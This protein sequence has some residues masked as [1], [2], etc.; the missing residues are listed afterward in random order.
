MFELNFVLL[1]KNTNKV[2]SSSPLKMIIHKQELTS[3]LTGSGATSI[4]SFLNYRG[5]GPEI[6]LTPHLATPVI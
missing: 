2:T 1:E 6:F 5:D 4:Q 3:C